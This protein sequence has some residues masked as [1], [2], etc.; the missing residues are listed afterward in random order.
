M[1]SFRSEHLFLYSE[2]NKMKQCCNEFNFSAVIWGLFVH[3]S[4]VNKIIS[5]DS[6]WVSPTQWFTFSSELFN[7]NVNE[8]LKQNKAVRDV[9]RVNFIW[10]LFLPH[11]SLWHPVNSIPMLPVSTVTVSYSSCHYGNS[12]RLGGLNLR[13]RWCL[14]KRIHVPGDAKACF[15]F[16]RQ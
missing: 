14:C 2:S 15:S 3:V 8:K 12:R 6:C 16:W 4:L 1:W 7:S 11:S 9:W 13:H 5:A 10:F